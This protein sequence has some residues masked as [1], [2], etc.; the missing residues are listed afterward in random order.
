M[1][2]TRAL[3]VAAF[4]AAAAFTLGACGAANTPAAPSAAAPAAT[5]AAPAEVAAGP[6]LIARQTPDLGTIVADVAG[7]TLY[8]FDKDKAKPPTATCVDK[9]ATTWPPAVVDPTAKLTIEGVDQSAIGLVKR[10]DGTSQL[11]I[12]GWPVYRFSGD[13]D[14]GSTKGQGV[15]GTWF[16][17]TPEGKKAP[18]AA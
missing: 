8:R 5:V 12:G 17:V 13:A 7:F 4:A 16:A 6:A 18:A 11:T 1:L 2:R 14:A 3:T 10:P 9:C 15:G